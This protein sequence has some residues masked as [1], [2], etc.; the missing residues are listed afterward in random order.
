MRRAPRVQA[1][2]AGGEG[3]G[4][5]VSP[6]PGGRE[7]WVAEGS[8]RLPVPEPCS[9]SR[10]PLAPEQAARRAAEQARAPVVPFGVDLCYW[11]QEELA[12]GKILK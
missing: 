2:G 8:P 3:Q 12:A 4:P 9:L 6:G 11:G 7:R 10:A 5:G 1:R